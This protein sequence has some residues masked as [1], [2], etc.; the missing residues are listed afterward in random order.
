MIP[1]H[2][3]Y[4]IYLSFSSKMIALHQNV[5]NCQNTLTMLTEVE[6]LSSR[7]MNGLNVYDRHGHDTRLHSSCTTC[8]KGTGRY[9]LCLDG[10]G[11]VTVE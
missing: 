3:L 8:W 2:I 1:P 5:A 11:P 7:Y 6:D 4:Q 9:L 10:V